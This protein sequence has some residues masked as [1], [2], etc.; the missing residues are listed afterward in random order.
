MNERMHLEAIK[1]F[2]FLAK[3]AEGKFLP[4]PVLLEHRQDMNEQNR[5]TTH[6]NRDTDQTHRPR[7]SPPHTPLRTLHP[8]RHE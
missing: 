3:A 5:E 6:L 1:E 2:V 7:R 4:W 8:T